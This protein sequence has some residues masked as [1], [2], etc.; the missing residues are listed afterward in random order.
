MHA[1]LSASKS[2]IGHP[3]LLPPTFNPT[4]SW[5]MYRCVQHIPAPIQRNISHSGLYSIKLYIDVLELSGKHFL[6]VSYS[7]PFEQETATKS[8]TPNASKQLSKP[9]TTTSEGEG[10]LRRKVLLNRLP[11]GPSRRSAQPEV[12]LQA[13]RSVTSE[14]VVSQKL[15]K[16]DTLLAGAV[17]AEAEKHAH[18]A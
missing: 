14:Y 8:P 16:L 11:S 5:P 4:P 7:V 6:H 10:P 2:Q 3:L 13:R 18:L 9:S 17:R 15:G 1:S 12:L